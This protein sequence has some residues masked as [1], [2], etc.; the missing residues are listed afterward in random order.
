MVAKMLKTESGMT[1]RT[2]SFPGEGIMQDAPLPSSVGRL[3]VGTPVCESGLFSCDFIYTASVAHL[4]EDEI[5]VGGHG[6]GA[7]IYPP[8]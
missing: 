6:G 1:L 8:A 2:R 3:Q 7:G 5:K 4:G